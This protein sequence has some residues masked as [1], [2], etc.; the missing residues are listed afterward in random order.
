MWSI[1]S[2]VAPYL[3]LTA[4]LPSEL[5]FFLIRLAALKYLPKSFNINILFLVFTIFHGLGT[6]AVSIFPCDEVCNPE[7][8][9]P[10][11]SQFIHNLVGGLTYLMGP[12]A[13]LFLKPKSEFIGLFERIIEAGILVWV[14]LTLNKLKDL[15][16]F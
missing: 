8:I 5:C 3:N 13:I 1:L 2:W 14:L 9:D 10:S 15:I 4:I 7:L 16:K 12:M 11:I 6:I